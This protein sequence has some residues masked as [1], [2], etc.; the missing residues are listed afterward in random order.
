MRLHRPPNVFSRPG[1]FAYFASTT[2]VSLVEPV[3]EVAH[4]PD[5]PDQLV[6]RPGRYTSHGRV[7]EL[8][9]EGLY[10][11]LS[12]GADNQQRIVYASDVEALLS[13]IAWIVSHGSTDN[14]L[15]DEQ[16][17]RR[18]M[19]S[20]LTLVCSEVSRWALSLLQAELRQARVLHTNTSE[21]PNGYNDGHALLEVYRPRLQRWVAYDLS[22]NASFW[23]GGTPLSVLELAEAAD[24]EDYE[25]R[26]LA[27]D[28][29]VNVSGFIEGDYDYALFSELIGAGPAALKQFYARVLDVVAMPSGEA[30]YV[31][32]PANR[33]RVEV[34]GYQ[35]LLVPRDKFVRQYYA[36][37]NPGQH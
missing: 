23:R 19:T 18:A 30:V 16:L 3:A 6:I 37:P 12:P 26:P 13:G 9:A 1:P 17:T 4:A 27:A 31:G 20:K 35:F 2:G 8:T 32:D 14:Q 24:A 28:T 25:I 5:L 22:M 36:A 34:T 10:R 11:F 33:A 29:A 15:D 7:Y 21:E